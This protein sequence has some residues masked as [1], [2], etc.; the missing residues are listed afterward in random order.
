MKNTHT[1]GPW[2]VA[3][4]KA[5][6]VDIIYIQHGSGWDTCELHGDYPEKNANARLIAAAP[7]LLDAAIDA[8]DL[9][10]EMGAKG[11]AAKL[12]A[13]IAKARGIK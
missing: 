10:K 4:F 3:P 12:K 1:P 11:T 2:R 9:A 8:L 5:G 13:A 7:D 6:D